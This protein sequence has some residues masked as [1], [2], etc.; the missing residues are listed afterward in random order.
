[1]NVCISNQLKFFNFY[2]LSLDD[3]IVWIE[4]NVSCDTGGQSREWMIAFDIKC[5]KASAE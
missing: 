3:L 4:T 2:C 5:M 1:M